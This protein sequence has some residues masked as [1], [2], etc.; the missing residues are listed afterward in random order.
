MKSKYRLAY[1]ALS[2]TVA[3]LFFATVG[4]GCAEDTPQ[5]PYFNE[6]PVPEHPNYTDDGHVFPSEPPSNS[7][8]SDDG[9]CWIHPA[10]SPT[11]MSDL[12]AVDGEVVGVGQIPGESDLHPM[13]WGDPLEV[14]DPP[15]PDSAVVSRIVTSANGWIALTEGDK[16]YEFDRDGIIDTVDFPTTGYRQIE[17]HSAQ[18]FFGLYD[19]QDS[20]FLLRDGSVTEYPSLP[21]NYR[22]AVRLWPDGTVWEV[23]DDAEQA[24]SLEESWRRFQRPSYEY[25]FNI[26]AFGPDPTSACADSGIW[27]MGGKQVWRWNESKSKWNLRTSEFRSVDDMGCRPDGSLA[28]VDRKGGL[29]TYRGGKWRRKNLDPFR[30]NELVSTQGKT[31][32]AGER[33]S[34]LEVTDDGVRDLS[35]GFRL[36]PMDNSFQSD[37]FIGLWFSLDG[38]RGVL[39]HS[40]HF[41]HGTGDGWKSVPRSVVSKDSSSVYDE[42]WGIRQPRFAIRRGQLYRWRNNRWETTPAGIFDDGFGPRDIAGQSASDVWV[43]RPDS[44]LHYD[45]ESWT[46][47]IEPPGLRPKHTA[48]LMEPGGGVTV[49]AGSSVYELAGQ[50]GSWN[51][52]KVTD[53][54]C[55][56]IHDLH[57]SDSGNLYVAG[58][59]NCAARRNSDGWS[60]YSV[61][62]SGRGSGLLQARATFVAQPGERPPLLACQGGLYALRSDG[63]SEKLLDMPLVDATYVRDKNAVALLARDGVLA[64]YY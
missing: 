15:L 36:P 18:L 11:G 1:S 38:N 12:R 23:S 56:V 40:S 49:A 16:L 21:E 6:N 37:G 43:L 28:V 10:P 54:P 2:F 63:S 55:D 57:R 48:L 13:V 35:R 50:P 20:G 64:K 30:L 26:D 62:L 3:T 25:S 41:Y 14:V 39:N 32:V 61:R 27:V 52:E 19:G 51:L 47:A 17:A 45:G 5:D 4:F 59:E 29:I 31:F 58:E 33:G 22:T 24:R 60:Q 34:M 53:S 44:M 9:W 8:C 42:V 7:L 46:Q